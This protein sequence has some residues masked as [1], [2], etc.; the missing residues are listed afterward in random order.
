MITWI[1][2]FDINVINHPLATLGLGER[3]GCVRVIPYGY[4]L[5][6]L[7]EKNKEDTS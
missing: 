5:R 2:N 7:E 3:W 6:L 1:V 4:C